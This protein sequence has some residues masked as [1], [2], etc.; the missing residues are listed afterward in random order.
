MMRWDGC[1]CCIQYVLLGSKGA[2]GVWGDFL[3]LFMVV[4]TTYDAH[5]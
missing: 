2:G 4:L 5:E 3:V 1:V